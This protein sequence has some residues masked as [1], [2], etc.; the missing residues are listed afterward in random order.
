MGDPAK[1][2]SPEDAVFGLRL[3]AILIMPVT[4]AS[5][6]IVIPKTIHVFINTV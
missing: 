1:E 6:V 3:P 5:P 2:E 4:K